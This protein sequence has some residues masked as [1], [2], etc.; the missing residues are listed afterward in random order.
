MPTY[1]SVESGQIISK[2]V[3]F[4]VN[5]EEGSKSVEVVHL[6]EVQLGMYPGV[7]NEI[8]YCGGY[9]RICVAEQGIIQLNNLVAKNENDAL[10]EVTEQIKKNHNYIYV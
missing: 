5:L 4:V 8:I 9:R 10:V 1:T 6:Y 2:I 3:R 7:D